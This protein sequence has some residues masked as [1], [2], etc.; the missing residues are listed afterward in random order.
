MNIKKKLWFF[1]VFLLVIV[2][3]LG[4]TKTIE[5]TKDIYLTEGLNKYI[6]NENSI[7][8][9]KTYNDSIYGTIFNTAGNNTILET[10]ALFSYSVDN[11]K[12]QV[13]NYDR[14]NRI[15]D[16]QIND[17]NVYFIELE[18]VNSDEYIW[19]LIKSD[20]NLLTYE[21]IK[22]GVIENPFLYPRIFMNNSYLI[23]VAISDNGDEQEY[24][25]SKMVEENIEILQSEKGYKSIHEGNLLFNIENVF[26]ANHRL[27][28]TI[29]DENNI[30]YLKCLDTIN[31]SIKVLYINRNENEI[32]YNYKPLNKGIYIQIALKNQDD[33]AKFIYMQND[34]IIFKKNTSIKTMD[35]VYNNV[36]LFHNQGNIFEVFSED[37]LR[38]KKFN[39]NKK[40]IYPRYVVL[41]NK[42]YIQDFK[43]NFYVS[44]DL[45]E[46]VN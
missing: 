2:F 22:S 11:K 19:R 24:E 44:N 42:I 12:L 18:E 45:T 39:V 7:E 35:T 23:L 27:Y 32:I 25:I 28:Y 34:K 4:K 29:V 1:I 43:N 33:L 13:Y 26:F 9:M 31:N 30:Q 14:K 46:Y 8:M 20:L 6:K 3:V 21:I 37:K 10:T 40:D 38:I 16:F 17:N 15:M 36:L 41:N 5:F